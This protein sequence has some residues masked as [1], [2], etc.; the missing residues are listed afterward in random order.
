MAT[1]TVDGGD[2][3]VDI[4]GLDKLWSFKS[5]LTVPLAHVRA[6]RADPT[7][8]DEPK[9]WRGP[10]SHIPGVIIAGTFHPDGQRVFW[11]VHDKN[12]AVVLDLHDE[13]YQ[14]LIVGVDDPVAT[15]ALIE[16]AVAGL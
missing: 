8:V 9:G 1:I 14:R 10:G 5:R 13:T 3:I 15:V 16:A 7:V 6:V 12:K 4:E 2:L 11:D